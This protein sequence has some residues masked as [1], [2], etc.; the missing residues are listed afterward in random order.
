MRVATASVTSLT[1]LG[2]LTYLQTDVG[3]PLSPVQLVS[4]GKLPHL[5]CSILSLHDVADSVPQSAGFFFH[6]YAIYG[7]L[8]TDQQPT[9]TVRQC[10]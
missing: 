10:A 9:A 5:R 2:H 1:M 8:R 7:C 4:L 6:P 3:R